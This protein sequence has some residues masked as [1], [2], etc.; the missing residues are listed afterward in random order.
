MDAGFVFATDAASSDGVEIAE[1]VDPNLHADN[2]YPIGIVE[3]TDHPEAARQV[4]DYLIS[5]EAKEVYEAY[6]YGGLEE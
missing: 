3:D 6:G 5:D 4:F 2:L 1:T